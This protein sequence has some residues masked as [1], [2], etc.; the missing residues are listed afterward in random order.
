MSLI[1]TWCWGFSIV[2]Y[3]CVTMVTGLKKQEF[4]DLISNIKSMKESCNRSVRTALG[5]L[6]TKLRL[7]LSNRILT[8]LFSIGSVRTTAKI[9]HQAR[10]ALLKDFVPN[11]MGVGHITREE[12]MVIL[13]N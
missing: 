4:N 8:T 9:V 3:F 6:L 7:S 11:Y 12:I 5:L 2:K 13:L 1:F 10:A